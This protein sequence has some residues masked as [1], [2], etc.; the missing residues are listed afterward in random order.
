MPLADIVSRNQQVPFPNP[1]AGNM[2]S[3]L[4]LYIEDLMVSNPKLWKEVTKGLQEFINNSGAIPVEQMPENVVAAPPI[5]IPA[6]AGN[7]QNKRKAIEDIMSG[8]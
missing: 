5:D 2:K 4:E 6:T 1:Q 8:I 7:I 3:P